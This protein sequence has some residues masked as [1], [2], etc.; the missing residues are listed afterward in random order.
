MT[1][2]QL[3]KILFFIVGI[4]ISV[5]S[6][7][8]EKGLI[9]SE[10]YSH[11]DYLAGTQNWC[12]AQDARGVMYFGNAAGILEYDGEEWRLIRVSN[13]STVRSLAFDNNNILYAGAYGEFGYLVPNNS[14]DLHYHSL[15]SLIDTSVKDFGEIWDIYTFSD[16]VFF[17]SDKYIF[18][19]HKNKIDIWESVGERFYLSHKI[20]NSYYVQEMGVGLLKFEKDTLVLADKGS[21]FADKRIHSIIPYNED[22][23][24]CTRTKGL[25]LYEKSNGKTKIRSFS[26]I[27]SKTKDLNDYFIKNVCYHGI[28]IADSLYALSTIT[29]NII[30]INKD[31]DVLD[32]INEETIGVKTSI[33][34]LYQ[35]ENGPLW[36]ALGNGICQVDVLSPYRF[37]GD[38]KGL[39]G[40]F[41]DI[42]KLNDYLYVTTSAGIFYTNLK[43]TPKFELNQFHPV[44]GTFEQSWGFRYFQMPGAEK[45]D[46]R[47]YDLKIGD[48]IVTDKTKLLVATSR[49]LFE[50]DK[51]NSHLISDHNSVYT[52]YQYKKDPSKFFLGLDKGIALLSYENGK[53]KDEGLKYGIENMIRNIHE[54]TLGNL[55]LIANYKGVYKIE[56]PTAKNPDSV[57]VEFLDTTNNLPTVTNVSA[58]IYE[59]TLFFFARNNYYTFNEDS[60]MFDLY[61]VPEDTAYEEP[62]DTLSLFRLADVAITF[63]YII[64]IDD[65]YWWFGTTLGMCRNSRRYIKDLSKAPPAI[66]R[67]VLVNDSVIYF[68]TNYQNNKTEGHNLIPNPSSVVDAETILEYR[69]NSITFIYASPSFEKESKNV[70]SYYLEGFDN[71]WSDWTSE[72]KKEYTNLREGEYIFKVK[73]KNIYRVESPIA[74]FNFTILP[75]WYRSFGALIAYAFIGILLIILIV[76]LYTYRLLKEKD[77][78]E[79]IVIERTQEILMQKEEILVQ[80]EHLKEA[81]ERISAKNKELEQQKW[82]I[83]NQAIKLKKA[84]IELLKLSKVASETDNAIA[85]F[86]KDGNI[87]WVNDGF[88]RLYGYTLEEFKKEK[89][90]NIVDGTFNPNIKKAILSCINEKKSIVYEFNT[91][92]KNGKDIWAQTALTHVVD[93]D[94]NT[95]NL[96]AIDSDITE[97][98]LAQKELAEQRDK[99]AISN[100]TKNKFFRIIAHDLR[101]PISTL[102]GSTNLIFND[103]DEYDKEQTKNFIGELNKLSQTTFNLLE[104]LLDWS[105]TQMGDIS[106]VPKSIDLK[107]IVEEAIELIKR[108][109]NHKNISLKLNIEKHSVAL[110]DENMVRTIFRN[111]LSNAV[112]FTPE[113]GKIE[114][115]TKIEDDLIYCT[116]KDSG[117]GIVKEDIKKLFKIDQ[118]YTRLG[119]E[120]EKG[121]GLG[122]ILCK[123][124]V[125]KN[126]GKIKINSTPDVGTTIEFTLRKYTV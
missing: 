3:N 42:A 68:G 98:K 31:W 58:L 109:I 125:E 26:E 92:N 44:N 15:T 69:D 27:S 102:A 24:I 71:K 35:Q 56:N 18:R 73:S 4:L 83:T 59:D 110:A 28:Q 93:K 122:L 1:K 33:H 21:F 75:P 53:W 76:K 123:E 89:N 107:F 72:N 17:L 51:G 49:G 10:Y 61:V 86:D 67:K 80:A 74:E 87:E 29:G 119:L 104:N 114:I 34:Y 37:W 63:E 46:D 111:L 14:G 120:N 115:T 39:N 116:V 12:I 103:F 16:T 50:L 78:L 47:V 124:F 65:P 62:E 25:Y 19:Y 20:E 64:D 40:T 7:A 81:N 36:L 2:I 112:K 41:T 45:L 100:A 79:K 11:K 101:N 77:K 8:Q 48:I 23:L 126:G 94:G 22:F 118:H 82:E 84:N 54:D 9:L 88:T 90:S 113:D 38:S 70:Y 55:W 30:V 66:I 121:S 95:L 5:F 13:N 57:K 91:K 60:N 52:T 105:S 108:K 96:I 117:I 32:I 106:F 97:L 6:T 85:I 43:G 99:L